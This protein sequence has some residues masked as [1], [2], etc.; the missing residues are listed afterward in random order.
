MIIACIKYN[1]I[2]SYSYVP[3]FLSSSFYLFIYLFIL[4][5]LLDLVL[6][7]SFIFF[8]L[9]I[10]MLVTYLFCNIYYYC[11]CCCHLLLFLFYLFL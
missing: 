10:Y 6:E 5:Y 1:F 3:I 9:Y 2:T 11:C 7:D 4:S 8:N